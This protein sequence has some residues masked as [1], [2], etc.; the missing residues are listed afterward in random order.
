MAE[1]KNQQAQIERLATENA[2]LLEEL[3]TAYREM[4]TLVE[5]AER[6]QALTYEALRERNQDLQSRLEELEATHQEL[7]EA[8]QLL[9][10]S[11]RLAAMGEMAAAIVHELKNPLNVM[12]G[13]LDLMKYDD[14]PVTPKDI[15]A[16][17]RSAVYLVK[18]TENILGFARQ[19]QGVAELLIIDDLIQAVISF[20]Q[21]IYKGVHIDLQL[22]PQTPL[23]H[24]DASKVEQVIMNLVL[25]AIDAMDKQGAL[26]LATGRGTVAEAVTLAEQEA[27]KWVLAIDIDKADQDQEFVYVIVKDDGP[28]I[29][30]DNL[31]RLFEAFF[32]TKEKGKGTGLGLSIVRTI[33]EEWGGN[34][35]LDSLE[36]EGAQFKVFI[37]IAPS[38]L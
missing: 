8:Q 9:V 27:R 34:I 33:V 12:L 29:P 24:I 6:E 5:S 19:H 17:H 32:T 21:P 35:L 2:A 16:L 28:G 7:K 14:L 31:A 25:N 30:E 13:R 3:E 18:L 23:V 22:D 10:R 37:P 20:V 4:E 11:E 15:D 1:S 26:F 38:E 36:D